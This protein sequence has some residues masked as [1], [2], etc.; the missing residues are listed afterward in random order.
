VDHPEWGQLRDTVVLFK[1]LSTMLP[2]MTEQLTLF[3]AE[4]TS[5]DE[6]SLSLDGGAGA[7]GQQGSLDGLSW[8][9]RHVPPERPHIAYEAV[10]GFNSRRLQ[11][12]HDGPWQVSARFQRLSDGPDDGSLAAL[13]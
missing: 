13:F 1:F 5:W 8:D 11:W 12:G 4:R 3:Q 10:Y 6:V 2:P 7:G 9:T